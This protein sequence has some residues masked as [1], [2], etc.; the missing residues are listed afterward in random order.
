[1]MSCFHN[2]NLRPSSKAQ[3][4]T[5]WLLHRHGLELPAGFIRGK[6]VLVNGKNLKVDPRISAMPA[7]FHHDAVEQSC[8][9]DL[10]WTGS[11]LAWVTGD[12]LPRDTLRWGGAG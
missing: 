10:S 12:L 11:L 2:C 7:V 5:Q 9:S 8:A 6:I 1:M 3:A 4:L